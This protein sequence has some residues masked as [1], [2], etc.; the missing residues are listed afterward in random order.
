MSL[1]PTVQQPMSDLIDRVVTLCPLPASAHRILALTSDPDVDIKEV[2]HVLSTD[3]ALTVEVMRLA[4]ST[5]YARGLPV[6]DL[7][8]A[9][10]RLGLGELRQMA[11][12]MAILAAFP[13]VGEFSNDLRAASVLSGAIVRDLADK[14]G[15]ASIGTAYVCGLLCEVGAMAC[16]AIDGASYL[17]LR[18]ESGGDWTIRASRERERYGH[19]SP[20]IGSELLNRNRL[21]SSIVQAVQASLD[22]APSSLAPLDRMTVFARHAAPI[23]IESGA[24]PERVD[25]AA[26]LTR[27]A[28]QIELPAGEPSELTALCVHS[29]VATVNALSSPSRR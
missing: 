29:A 26:R 14:S 4:N 11:G 25:L 5:A 13:T 28:Q 23:L 8:Q 6:T 20:E 16:T 3:P 19:S 17:E 21:P 18:A 15:F 27:L 9:V 12:A 7:V 2:G 1:Q 24:N 10:L 22:S